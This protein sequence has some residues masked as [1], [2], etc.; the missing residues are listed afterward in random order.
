MNTLFDL[1]LLFKIQNCPVEKCGRAFELSTT[2]SDCLH[3]NLLSSW[4]CCE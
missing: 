3:L 2:G 4:C 1:T